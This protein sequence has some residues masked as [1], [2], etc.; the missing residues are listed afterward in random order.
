MKYASASQLKRVYFAGGHGPRLSKVNLYTLLSLWM[1]L[2][3][4][5]CKESRNETENELTRRTGLVVVQ[6]RR[7][8]GLHCSGPELHAGQVAVIRHGHRL[9]GCDLYFS[10]K[11]CSTCLKMIINAGVSRISYWPGDPEISLL[12]PRTSSSS[13]SRASSL[14]EAELDAAAAEKL[15]SSSRPHMGVLLQPLS[16]HMQQFVEEESSSCDFQEKMASDG[17]AGAG[18][19]GGGGRARSS[20]RPS[21]AAPPLDVRELFRR[22]QW[23]NRDEFSRAF[24]DVDEANHRELLTKMGLVTFCTEPYFSNLRQHMTDLVRLLSSVASSVP[25]LEDG[26][27]GFYQKDGSGVLHPPDIAQDVLRHCIIQAQLLAFRTEDPKVGVGAVIWA[28]GQ[29]SSC[30]GTGNLHLVGC[31]YNAYPVGSEYGEYPQM[32]TKQK[33]R[34]S[35]KYRYII[36]AEQ[37]A[38]TFRSVEIKDREKTMMFVTK[39]P[40]DECVPL[41]RG[42]GIQQVYTTDLDS[43]KNKNDISYLKFDGLQGVQKYIW[44]RRPQT[45]D[46]SQQQSL[47]NGCLKHAR[48]AEEEPNML[49]NKRLRC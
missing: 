6:G 37:N 30:D 44:Q 27:Y 1:E 14:L 36:H 41:I 20:S 24:L 10:R 19:G 5:K 48:Q 8:L 45:R 4:Q 13:S 29:L 33:D 42:A 43:G 11:P 40:C 23:R 3:P 26:G 39:C 2:F 46:G 22:Q 16:C 35:R 12:L 47:A 49:S 18:A 34:Q 32:G 25:F 17:G 21:D 28:E 7:V 9:A 31:G 38:L 15:K